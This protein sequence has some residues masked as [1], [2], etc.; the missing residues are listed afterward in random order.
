ME[1]NN[2]TIPPPPQGYSNPNPYQQAPGGY[3]QQQGGA[4]GGQIDH[5]KAASINTLGII[6]LI[7][8]FVFGIV[9][10]I[11]NII[12]LSMSGGAMSDVN[13]NPGKYTEASIKK[14]KG[15]R[16]CAIVGLSIQGAV[17]LI[18]LLVLMAAM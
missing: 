6:G 14:I 4:F 12:A 16:T 17:V 1:N 10:L 8:T 5:P 18:L 9:G 2:P 7:C 3:Q 15:G 13:A 11:L